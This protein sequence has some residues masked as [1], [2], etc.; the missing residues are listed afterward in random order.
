M[1]PAPDT[2]VFDLDDTLYPPA[3][4]LTDQ[5]NHRIREYLSRELGVDEA[6]ARRAQAQLRAEHGTTLL[7]LMRTRGVEPE[8]FFRFEE[9]VDY[10]ALQPDPGLRDALLALP[11]RRLVLTNGSTTHAARVL[12]AL[13]LADEF[14]GVF[15]LQAAGLVPKP[16]RATYE[17]FLRTYD[18][19]PRRC[20]FFDDLPVNLE[21]PRALGMG[22]ALMT[23]GTGEAFEVLAREPLQLRVRDLVGTLTAL[24]QPSAVEPERL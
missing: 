7:G 19:D 6:G 24:S 12:A 21:E 11:G 4:G 8:D 14:D 2:W 13:E 16:H 17:L 10:S 9:C 15:D 20:L 5:M 3:V 23:G 18:A 22:T 1:S